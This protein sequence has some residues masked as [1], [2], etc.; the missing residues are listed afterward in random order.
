MIGSAA[1]EREVLVL[2]TGGTIAMRGACA[3]PA[4]GPSELLAAVGLDRVEARA[5]LGVP[6]AHVSLADA[7][8]V[9]RTAAAEAEAG[10]GVVVTHGT[11]TL[12]VTA[13]LCDLL[14]AG[15]APFEGAE[16]DLRATAAIPAGPLSPQ[17]ARMKLL[18]CL[19]PAYAARPSR[20]PSRTMIRKADYTIR[21]SV[22]VANADVV[23]I[24]GAGARRAVRDG[25]PA[26]YEHHGQSPDPC[27]G[28]M[29]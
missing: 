2:A 7:L 17:A 23:Y 26:T 1:M 15:E 16:G 13:V 12:E 10:R 28:A 14:Y 21:R 18:A 11:D 27:P 8:Q 22:F 5:L 25:S 20:R 4:A 19:G 9:A 3:V 29:R 6:G 24:A